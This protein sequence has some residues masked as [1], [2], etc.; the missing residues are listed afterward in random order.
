MVAWT[1]FRTFVVNEDG[2]R[3]FPYLNKDGERWNLNWNWIENDLNQ[4]GRI[5]ASRNWQQM[6]VDDARRINF[7]LRFGEATRR[8]FY[9]LR[10]IVQR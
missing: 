10:L 3:N 1:T 4:N 7:G 6:M 2:N 8:A 5:A 9:P